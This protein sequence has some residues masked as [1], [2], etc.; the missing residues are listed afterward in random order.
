MPEGNKMNLELTFKPLTP[1]RFADLETLFGFHGAASGC[2][3]MWWRLP[4][5]EFA[6]GAG[7]ENHKAFRRLVETGAE[8]GI[9]AYAEGKPVGW[10][11][12]APRAEYA[13]LGRSRVLKPIDQEP[14]WSITC[15]F[16]ARSLRRRGVMRE[17][18]RAACDFVHGKGGRI[19]EGYPIVPEGR[20]YPAAFA[21]P[22]LLSAFLDCGFAEVSR[23]SPKRAVVR[24]VVNA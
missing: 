24:F 12:I 20:S 5:K 11:A 17:L 9:L 18:I 3:C 7:E 14:V 6:A 19:V 2:W 13:R 4:A 10:C 22:G 15:F 23:P 8:P 16:V 21:Y 1:D